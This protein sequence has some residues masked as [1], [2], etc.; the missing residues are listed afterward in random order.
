MGIVFFSSGSPI[1]SISSSLDERNL[2]E[3][4]KDGDSTAETDP[5]VFG[6]QLLDTSSQLDFTHEKEDAR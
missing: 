6:G 4:N 2:A 1:S 3:V 5:E